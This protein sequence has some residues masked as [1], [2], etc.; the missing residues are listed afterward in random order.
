MLISIGGKRCETGSEGPLRV[1]YIVLFAFK[2]SLKYHNKTFIFLNL[3][4]CVFV[5]WK[6]RTNPHNAAEWS[7]HGF[8]LMQHFVQIHPIEQ[9]VV[10]GMTEV[11]SK[12]INPIMFCVTVTWA[13]AAP[14]LHEMSRFSLSLCLS[15]M[16]LCY[17]T[18][19][20]ISAD[21]C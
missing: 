12:S 21:W 4:Q 16:H 20:K 7:Q 9:F 11:F 17:V 2:P 6:H 1:H 3:S 19:H 15:V 8:P 13:N 18:T 5:A 10:S 14:P